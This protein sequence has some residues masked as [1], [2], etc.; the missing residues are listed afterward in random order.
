MTRSRIAIDAVSSCLVCCLLWGCDGS[1]ETSSKNATQ[2]PVENRVTSGD[3]PKAFNVHYLEAVQAVRRGDFRS[4]ERALREHLLTNPTDVKAME[5]A[6]DVTARTGDV[7][8]A[9]QWYRD[10]AEQSAV[11]SDAL[12]NKLAK[13]L[14]ANGLAYDSVEVLKQT[15]SLHPQLERPRY[16][17]AGLVTVLGLNRDAIGPLQWLIQHNLSDEESLVVLS[18]PDRVQP[19]PEFCHKLLSRAPEDLRPHFALAKLDAAKQDWLAVSQRLTPVLQ[20]HSDFLPAWALQGQALVSLAVANP[21]VAEYRSSLIQWSQAKPAG[22]EALPEYWNAAGMWAKFTGDNASAVRSFTEAARLHQSNH[23][24]SLADLQASLRQFGRKAEAEQVAQRFDHI[25]GLNDAVKT[26]LERNSQSQIAALKVAYRMV[27][28]GRI[29]EAEAWTR[30]AKSLPN[31]PVPSIEQAHLAIR[32]RLRAD[33]PWQSKSSLVADSI[34]VSD[35]PTVSWNASSN[36]IREIANHIDV[37]PLQFLEQAAELGLKHTVSLAPEA[38]SEGHWIYQ[39]TGG[40]AAVLDFDLNG[41]PDVALANLDGK[42]LIQN[43]SPNQLF[44]NLEGHFQNTTTSSSYL[45]TGFAQGITSGDFND[46]G[47]PDLFDAN[48]G[49]NRLYRNNGDGT[50]SDATDEMGLVGSEWTTS[51][52]IAD[53]DGDGNA[54]IFEVNYCGGM[55][56]YETPCRS[57]ANGKLS[58]CPPLKFEASPDRVWSGDGTGGFQNVSQT[59]M[60]PTSIGRGLGIIAGQLDELPG[61]DL[62]IANDMSVNHLWSSS[63]S[64]PTNGAISSEQTTRLTDIGTVRGLAM[65]GQSNSQASMGM[66][67]GDPDGDGDLDFFLTHFAEEHNTY[68]EQVAPGLWE[69]RTHAVGLYEPSL[70][71]LGFGTTWTDFNLDGATELLITNGHVSETGRTDIG[72]QMPPQMFTRLASGRW[73]AVPNDSLG[74]YFE[75][76]HLGRALVTL[77]ANCDGRTDAL[78]THLYEPVAL[79]INASQPASQAIG[80]EFKATTGHRDAIGTTVEVRNPNDKRTLQLTGGDGYMGSQERKLN[81][82]LP[83]GNTTSDIQVHWPSGLSQPFQDLNA[84]QDYLLVEGI[85]KPIPMKK[86]VQ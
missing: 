20:Q 31:D 46:D 71:Q 42:P 8:Q 85:E 60:Q 56:P 44:R 77:D 48:V 7:A 18:N 66:A 50:F 2:E 73:K 26:F 38:E 11:P 58:S 70:D 5:L 74:T 76:L 54:D 59:W 4:A 61:L 47:F 19:D 1:G 9:I 12:L 33:T 79:L 23:G 75:Q 29:W 40:G 52:V 68:Y 83:G 84:G 63:H 17:L 86:H 45:D 55:A 13:H 81:L 24:P 41:W 64:A 16:D 51:A 65:S 22:L 82:P 15:I 62:F 35:L 28:L 10:A 39:S 37:A 27:D 30:L 72:Y 36:R 6:G 57:E 80:L 32:S 78:I 43:S 53:V 3:S 67:V 69:D 25:A 34:Q 14:M 21:E 49:R